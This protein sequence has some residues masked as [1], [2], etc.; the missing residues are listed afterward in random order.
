MRKP[1][2]T[3]EQMKNEPGL[4]YDAGKPR[5]DLI[6]PEALEALAHV[7]TK[8]AEKYADRNWEKGMTWGRCFRAMISHA[9]A[10]WAGETFD[11]ELGC[12][13]LAMA[14]WNAF[15]LLTYQLREVGTDDRVKVRGDG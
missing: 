3:I 7:Y 2:R 1:K 13:H 9:I 5:Y 10:W 4:R 15:A 14:A 12:H 6:P 11:K 8:G